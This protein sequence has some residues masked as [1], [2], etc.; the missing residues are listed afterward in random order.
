[1]RTAG[2][3]RRRFFL[4]A[5]DYCLLSTAPSSGRGLFD[6]LLD[7]VAEAGEFGRADADADEADGAAAVDEDG[8]G[9][10]VDAVFGQILAGPLGD[11]DRVGHPVPLFEAAQ[12][13]QLLGAALV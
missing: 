9:E 3:E 4:P 13:V 10:G 8:G 1:M 11:G 7:H 12:E 2:F 5:T 6:Q